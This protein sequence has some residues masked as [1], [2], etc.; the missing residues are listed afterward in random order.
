MIWKGWWWWWMMWRIA[1]FAIHLFIF[2]TKKNSSHHF[3]FG[4]KE[5]SCGYYNN[6][7]IQT[8]GILYIVVCESARDLKMKEIRI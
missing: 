3:I 8:R 4:K 6:K 2:S 7:N 1:N 5:G